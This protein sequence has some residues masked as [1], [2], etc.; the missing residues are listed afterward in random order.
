MLDRLL[1]NDIEDYKAK[2]LMAKAVVT[3]VPKDNLLTIQNM[4]SR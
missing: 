3:T 2:D 1:K 4:M